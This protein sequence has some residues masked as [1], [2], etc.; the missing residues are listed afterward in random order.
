[1]KPAATLE[2]L[3]TLDCAAAVNAAAPPAPDGEGALVIEIVVGPAP[4]MLTTVTVGNPATTAELPGSVDWLPDPGEESL[5][6]DVDA[7]ADEDPNEVVDEDAE[8]AP[9]EDETEDGEWLAELELFAGRLK[10]L[11]RWGVMAPAL[12]EGLMLVLNV[13]ECCFEALFSPLC[14][15]VA[16]D[17]VTKRES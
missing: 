16:I 17:V 7:N 6:A 1:M 13:R 14:C 5:G 11:K 2:A 15:G 10:L 12:L 4:L 9:D 8:G 3:E